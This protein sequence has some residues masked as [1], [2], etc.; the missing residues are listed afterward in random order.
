MAKGY[1]VIKDTRET[2]G[3]TFPKNEKYRCDGMVN[4]KLDTGDYTLR[5]LEDVLCI[6][7]KASAEEMSI[8]LGK[9]SKR[10]QR[11][12]ERMKPFKHKILLLEFSMQQML[13]FPNHAGS[14]VPHVKRNE[15][16]IT[17]AFMLKRLMEIQIEHDVHILFCGSRFAALK[18]I[19]SIF[20]R[21][22]HL[23]LFDEE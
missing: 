3:Y 11:E 18:T 15:V 7:R 2:E 8:N 13:D 22:A 16:R 17:G 23:Y 1:I 12:I 14:R 21:M 10:F 19:S 9:E 20:K 4:T 5:G 6:E